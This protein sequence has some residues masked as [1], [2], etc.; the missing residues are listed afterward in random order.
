MATRAGGATAT[1]PEMVGAVFGD[2]K[3][4]SQWVLYEKG[5]FVHWENGA[6]SRIRSTTMQDLGCNGAQD[7]GSGH[8]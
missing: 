1:L 7:S 6:G 8:H 4:A 3:V 2:Y 5:T